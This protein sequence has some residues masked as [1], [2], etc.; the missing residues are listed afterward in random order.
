MLMSK[1]YWF[2][3]SKQNICTFCPQPKRQ[4]LPSQQCDSSFNRSL[5]KDGI[6]TYIRIIVSRKV[7]Q[8]FHGLGF[9]LESCPNPSLYME[10]ERGP[11]NIVQWGHRPYTHPVQSVFYPIIENNA[12]NQGITELGPKVVVEDR[13]R[14]FSSRQ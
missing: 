12:E 8:I 4:I 14:W 11:T 6:F 13:T 7:V 10:K 5:L 9:I 1:L 2:L 3:L